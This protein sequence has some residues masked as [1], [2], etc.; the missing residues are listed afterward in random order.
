[1]DDNQDAA[2]TAAA[3]LELAGYE[4]RVAYDPGVALTLLDEFRPQVA[5][6][7]IGLPGMSGYELAAR[8]RAHRNC[9]S[10][11]LVALTGYGTVSDLAKGF[12]AGFQ[13]HLV[14]PASPDALLD[15]VRQGMQQQGHA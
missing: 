10:C 2:D 14:K 7:D 9:T 3:L 8:V 15:A 1:V 12:D 5:V 13:Q 4:V 11:Y 6:L